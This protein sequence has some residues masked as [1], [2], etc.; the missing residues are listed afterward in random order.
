VEKIVTLPF[1][2]PEE[3]EAARRRL[4]EEGFPSGEATAAF[5]QK[6]AVAKFLRLP[7]MDPEELAGMVSLQAGRRM[8]FLPEE[9]AV[10]SE[11][12]SSA[13][14]YSQVMMTV[15]RREDV[16]RIGEALR[17]SGIP[18]AR[19]VPAV[20]AAAPLFKGKGT[21]LLTDVDEDSSSI[22][23]Q[24][25]GKVRS[26]RSVP[27]GVSSFRE[28]PDRLLREILLSLKTFEAE[29]PADAPSRILLAGAR[30]GRE[31]LAAALRNSLPSL[32]VDDAGP[33]GEVQGF[34][35]LPALGAACFPEDGRAHLLSPQERR[36]ARGIQERKE[37]LFSAALAALLAVAGAGIVFKSFAAKR[38]E[39]AVLD[40]RLNE[41]APE[42]EDL[43]RVEERLSR[44]K[45][46]WGETTALPG[47]M[48]RL[49]RLAPARISLSS[50]EFER[51]KVLSLQG[52][53]LAL[54]DAVDFVN[55]LQRAGLFQGVEL[56]SSS[57]RPFQGRDMVNFEIECRLRAGSG[58]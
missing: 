25:N 29:N 5:P 54:S 27:A 16:R 14:G 58:A 26:V 19:M 46:R 43:R 52:T 1:S 45:G 44:M 53:T 9:M 3:E 7:S 6:A 47:L 57:M 33:D 56:K 24:G 15:A 30:A 20:Q 34:S 10:D 21:V 18:A 32:P 40:R 2:S 49:N 38:A 13:E 31:A 48:G 8:P 41:L 35:I 22:A 28:G 36:E 11:V 42:T 12:L 17:R 23:I 50:V 51:D 4:A 37:K 55:A 39:I